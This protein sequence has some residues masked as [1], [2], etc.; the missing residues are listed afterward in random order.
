MKKYFE[1]LEPLTV[2]EEKINPNFKTWKKAWKKSIFNT[3]KLKLKEAFNKYLESCKTFP[4][5]G[6]NKRIG[7][8][9]YM[10]WFIELI[11]NNINFRLSYVAEKELKF[12]EQSYVYI[13]L[14]GIDKKLPAFIS[15]RTKKIEIEKLRSMYS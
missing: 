13:G 2:T 9:Y 5:T 1:E 14:V 7:D 12:L 4:L 8:K 6:E 11:D 15:N 3:G 10:S